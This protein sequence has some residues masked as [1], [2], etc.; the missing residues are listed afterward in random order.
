M[1]S[2]SPAADDVRMNIVQSPVIKYGLQGIVPISDSPIK[3]KSTF[4]KYAELPSPAKRYKAQISQERVAWN[5]DIKYDCPDFNS[6][7]NK[8]TD[9]RRVS[10]IIPEGNDNLNLRNV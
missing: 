4:K 6:F 8:T 2:K 5:S 7:K 1:T 3:L 9:P 10:L